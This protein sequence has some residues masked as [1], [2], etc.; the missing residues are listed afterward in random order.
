MGKRTQQ[1]DLAL[2]ALADAGAL[3]A[4]EAEA[5]AITWGGAWNPRTK[6]GRLRR[7]AG[8]RAEGAARLRAKLQGA[9]Q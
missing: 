3:Q 7:A 9:G 8:R 1:A 6:A 5:V 4:Q 2:R